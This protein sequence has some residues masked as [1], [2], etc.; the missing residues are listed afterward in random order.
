MS[1]KGE[2]EIA[3]DHLH[4]EANS[5]GSSFCEAKHAHRGSISS[6]TKHCSRS[7]FLISSIAPALWVSPQRRPGGNV[8]SKNCHLTSSFW[9]YFFFFFGAGI[10]PRTLLLLSTCFPCWATQSCFCP[11]CYSGIL[12]HTTQ[13]ANLPF[14]WDTKKYLSKY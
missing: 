3:Y 2:V 9:F 4:S 11:A 8:V 7:A 12:L 6:H 5:M 13:G 1:Y 14:F 10:K